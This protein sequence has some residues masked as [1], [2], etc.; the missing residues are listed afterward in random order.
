MFALSFCAIPH[1]HRWQAEEMYNWSAR[2]RVAK[3]NYE[4]QGGPELR[5]FPKES[6]HCRRED[7][8]GLGFTE[9]REWYYEHMYA[10]AHAHAEALASTHSPARAHAHTHTHVGTHQGT[11]DHALMLALPLTRSL[12]LSTGKLRDNDSSCCNRPLP[13]RPSTIQS[14]NSGTNGNPGSECLC[15]CLHR[16]P[17]L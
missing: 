12:A 6:D 16:C 13:R 15:L 14:G 7:H 9:Q 11:S 1:A 5:K 2:G 10:R 17:G 3:V 8:L 4:M